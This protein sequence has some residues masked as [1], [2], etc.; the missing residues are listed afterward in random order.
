MIAQ[1]EEQEE[2][3]VAHHGEGTSSQ[4]RFAHRAGS[5]K[6]GSIG[7]EL[8]DHALET[9]RRQVHNSVQMYRACRRLMFSERS[10]INV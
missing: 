2:K 5:D 3:R 10:R 6:S 1:T 7:A 9:G 8:A 4:K